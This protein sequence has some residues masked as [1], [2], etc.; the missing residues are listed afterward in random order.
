MQSKWLQ[1]LLALLVAAV[2]A[3]SPLAERHEEG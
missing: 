1:L 3:S 2:A